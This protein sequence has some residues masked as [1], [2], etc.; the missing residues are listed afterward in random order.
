MKDFF[1][2]NGLLILIIA[3]LLAAITAVFSYA[4]QGAPS[5]LSNVLGV[6]TTPVRNGVSSLAEWVEGIYSYTFRYDEL[7]A[8]NQRLQEENARLQ[9]ELRQA[10][11]DS[12]ENTFP[13]T[14]G[15]GGVSPAFRSRSLASACSSSWRILQRLISFSIPLSSTCSIIWFME[16]SAIWQPTLT[17]PSTSFVEA[18]IPQGPQEPHPKVP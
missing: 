5:P 8:E 16:S 9:Q 14:D 7:E 1:Q 13:A 12:Q 2:K 17:C 3:V 4:F 6:V 18:S 11:A 10:S 15:S